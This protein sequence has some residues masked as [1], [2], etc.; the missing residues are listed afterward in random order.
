MKKTASART[1]AGRKSDRTPG[2]QPAP[3]EGQAAKPPVRPVSQEMRI[4][5]IM[6][7]GSVINLAALR[8]DQIDFAHMASSLSKIARFCGRHHDA[9]VS[10]AQHSV[11]GADALFSETGDG[12][13]AGYF[14]LH[15][16]HE[17]LLGDVSRPAALMIAWMAEA[18]L[19]ERGA[20]PAAVKGAVKEGIDRAKAAIDAVI[21]QAAGLPALARMPAYRRQVAQMDERMCAAEGRALYPTAGPIPLVQTSL[22]P[23]KLTG[24][25]RGWGAMKAEEA[26]AERLDRYLGIV[27]R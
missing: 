4:P 10:V 13:L 18:C 1:A 16:G 24:A 5:N 11:M 20:D 7:D 15:D 12:V 22:P 9:A 25:I 8:A 27:T 23:P 2:G 6:H 17:Y 21:L 3:A 19:A 14:L 26:F